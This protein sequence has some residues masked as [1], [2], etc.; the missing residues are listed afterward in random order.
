MLNL[1]V[2]FFGLNLNELVM[3]ENLSSAKYHLRASGLIEGISYLL[4]L[5][6]AM[7]LK[8]WAG[9]PDFVRYVGAVHGGLFIWYMVSLIW[10]KLTLNLTFSQAIW[11]FAASLVPFGTFYADSRIF[12]NLKR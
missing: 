12:R 10:A 9:I 1:L 6:I 11:A 7:P 8:Y 4:L 5:F 2:L 3:Q